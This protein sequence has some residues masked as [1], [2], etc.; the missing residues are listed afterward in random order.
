MYLCDHWPLIEDVP[1]PQIIYSP[2]ATNPT[3]ASSAGTLD[4]G[5]IPI[6]NGSGV[7]STSFVPVV[8]ASGT[9]HAI[10][11]VPDPGSTAGTSKFL[12]EDAT[13]ATVTTNVF[14]ASGALH[15][16]GLVPDPGST[17]GNTHFLRED[18]T[19]ASIPV[20]IPGDLL[21]TLVNTEVSITGTV[22]LSSA[23]FSIMH[24]CSGT[25]TD[26]TV[27]IPSPIGNA[28]KLIGFRM[29]N[30]VLPSGLPLTK[31]VTISAGNGPKSGTVSV[32]SEIGLA[33]HATAIP[34]Q[35]NPPPGNRITVDSATPWPQLGDRVTLVNSSSFY[36]S[37]N[38]VIAISGAIYTLQ[39]NWV[40]G[41]FQI[42]SG[43]YSKTGV[44]GSNT[45][46]LTECP[47]GSTLTVNGVNRTVSYVIDDIHLAVDTVWPWDLSDQ[48]Y[49]GSTATPYLIDGVNNLVLQANEVAI[50]YCDGYEWTNIGGKSYA[51]M[52]VSGILTLTGDIT[53]SG[54]G[55]FVTTIANKNMASG[56]AALDSGARVPYAQMPTQAQAYDIAGFFQGKPSGS[57][58]LIY[59]PIVRS[60]T[61]PVG[62]TGSK[63]ISV[64]AALASVAYIIYK[65]GSSIGTMNFAPGATTATFTFATAT[66]F[67]SGDTLELV[68]P[69][70]VD[71]NQASIGF[72]FMGTLN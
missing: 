20:S 44:V 60:F 2:R 21:A 62:L 63:G 41:V 17:S 61:L 37:N 56:I 13:W 48:T 9:N 8:A 6:L 71:A 58:V 1:L 16:T 65:N 18:A 69:S 67:G 66:T 46:F 32:W 68:C 12:R 35:Y 15:S 70:T 31:K 55:S 57:S 30:S 72:T 19:W 22:G 59:I 49:A 11:L 3:T 50:L 28:G 45:K 54:N 53:G 14:N 27:T 10:G 51:S 5:K 64:V 42:S 33:L 24:V 4:A 39:N 43:T 40:S 29:A 34:Y 25:T 23:H 52:P 36:T 47:V 26:Y 7:L 38:L